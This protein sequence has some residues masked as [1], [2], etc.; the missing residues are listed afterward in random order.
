MYASSLVQSFDNQQKR[1]RGITTWRNEDLNRRRTHI[2]RSTYFLHAQ[3]H[4]QFDV[5]YINWAFGEY[6]K[7]FQFNSVEWENN[8][9]EKVIVNFL[10]S[11]KK[12]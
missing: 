7:A 9:N 5:A 2:K 11:H 10:K 1:P 3:F 6:N 12:K 8:Y 4:R